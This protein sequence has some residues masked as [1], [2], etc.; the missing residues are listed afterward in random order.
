LGGNLISKTNPLNV[1]LADGTDNIPFPTALDTGAFKT[2]E[3]NPITSLDVDNW[4]TVLQTSTSIGTLAD[5]TAAA[6][7]TQLT[8]NSTPC[9][10]VTVKAL[11]GNTGKVRVGDS[12]VTASRGHELSKDQAI[13]IVVNN[14]NLIY[15]F[16]NASDKVSVIYV[17]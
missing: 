8:A 12:N 5:V 11:A 1:R 6:S 13:D 17:N 9:K 16:G 2:R 3:Q 15:V 7:A 14:V 10:T 4:P